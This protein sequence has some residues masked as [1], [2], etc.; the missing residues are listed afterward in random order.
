[1]PDGTDTD[2]PAD[3]YDEAYYQALAAEADRNAASHRWRLRWL[4]EMLD[5]RPGERVV[6]LGSGTGQIARHLARRGA[7]VEAVDRSPQ[8]VA[9]CRHR[10]ADL[11]NVRFHVADA[12]RCD[13]LESAAF[14]KATCCDLIEH[15][16]DDVMIGVFREARRLLKPDG[17][18]YV[19]SPNAGHWIERLKARNCLLK[20]P[21][22]HI[23]VRGAAE[24][25]AALTDCG[26]EIARSARPTSMLPVV[27]RLEWVWLRLPISPDLAMYRVCLLARK[28]AG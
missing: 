5:V 14:D 18:L 15:V 22:G 21:V 23:R 7:V 9:F 13:H 24:V 1:M 12:T 11:K 27:R 10:W 6:D 20:Q 17:E 8:A 28:P 16:H 3:S 19:Y 26:F 4:D 25:A 2:Y